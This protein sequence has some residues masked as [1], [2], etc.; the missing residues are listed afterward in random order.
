MERHAALL[1]AVNVTGHN[2]MSMAALREVVAGLGYADVATVVQSGNVVF[3]A[4]GPVD[5]DAM[6]S[7]IEKAFGLQV[8][9]MIRSGAELAAVAEANPWPA[10][11]P[12][13]LHVGFLAGAAA[14]GAEGALGDAA[15][16]LPE[17]ARLSADRREVYYLLP[18]GIGRAKLPPALGR[19]LGVPLTVR[20]WNTLGKLITLTAS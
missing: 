9:V 19:R 7:A 10:A 3:G 14:G 18:N 1:R 13:S 5:G 17:E 4:D 20:N 8:D 16:F 15:R 6:A 11:P 2:P 12:S